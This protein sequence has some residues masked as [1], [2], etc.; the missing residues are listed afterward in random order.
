[1][2]FFS[3]WTRA[4]RGK[5]SRPIYNTFFLEK[6]RKGRQ[7]DMG[8]FCQKVW[9]HV[10]GADGTFASSHLEEKYEGYGVFGGVDYYVALSYC[11]P[12]GVPFSSL[13]IDE[14]RSRGIDLTFSSPKAKR[15]PVFTESETYDGSFSTEC[16]SC[17]G[18]GYWIEDCDR[19]SESSGSSEQESE[20]EEEPAAE[21]SSEKRIRSED[22]H[23]VVLVDSF[24]GRTGPKRS[25]VVGK[26]TRTEDGIKIRLDDEENL[27]F[28]VE[29]TIT[30]ECLNKTL[31]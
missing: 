14:H 30:A 19:L 4:Y 29:G 23:D 2:G 7:H 11:N 6:I 13:T 3:W 25:K 26:I 21:R 8:E 9:M 16:E 1:M 10:P 5:Q 17:E 24:R 18:Q 27:E 22:E 12:E 20:Q 15:F 31:K 28:W